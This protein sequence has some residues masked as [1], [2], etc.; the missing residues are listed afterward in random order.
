MAAS[1][2]APKCD[3]DIGLVF[4]L[5]CFSKPKVGFIY[6]SPDVRHNFL[7]HNAEE[8]TYGM[9]NVPSQ[10]GTLQF[11][12]RSCDWDYKTLP[13]SIEKGSLRLNEPRL[14]QQ[15]GQVWWNIWGWGHF[16]LFLGVGF[17]SGVVLGEVVIVACLCFCCQRDLLSIF[18]TFSWYSFTLVKWMGGGATRL[19]LCQSPMPKHLYP[20]ELYFWLDN[21]KF[22]VPLFLVEI[23]R[24]Q[25]WSFYI[26]DC[27]GLWFLFQGT[28]GEWVRNSYSGSESAVLVNYKRECL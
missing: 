9:R 12:N 8:L 24:S 7:W 1:P 28:S 10:V 11:W 14:L 23:S 2:L 13:P 19:Q 6:W 3:S 5:W 17:L 25:R 21:V 16:G 26:R 27:A 22:C 4:R 18:T 20:Q 15:H